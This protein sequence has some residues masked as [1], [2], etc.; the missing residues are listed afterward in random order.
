MDKSSSSVRLEIT[1]ESQ[2]PAALVLELAKVCSNP[3]GSVKNEK[4][5]ADISVEDTPDSKSAVGAL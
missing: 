5:D 3:G 2:S 4:H 1:S